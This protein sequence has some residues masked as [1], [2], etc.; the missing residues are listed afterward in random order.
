MLKWNLSPRWHTTKQPTKEEDRTRPDSQTPPLNST[1]HVIS[2]T[3]KL[4]SLQRTG[5]VRSSVAL[6]QPG[7]KSFKVRCFTLGR[8]TKWEREG[9]DLYLWKPR[10]REQ[11]HCL[12]QTRGSETEENKSE[13]PERSVVAVRGVVQ[14]LI[15]ASVCGWQ[16]LWRGKCCSPAETH[17]PLPPTVSSIV[18]PRMKTGSTNR[19]KSLLLSP[20]PLFPKTS[21]TSIQFSCAV[22]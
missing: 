10:Q 17:H 8:S 18:P 3:K 20:S 21:T 13:R 22:S 4:A 19:K 16:F 1:P 15:W 5:T 6:P 14:P 12:C 9:L 2:A 7:T 11:Q